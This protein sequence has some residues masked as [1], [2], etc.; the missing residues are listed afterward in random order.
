MLQILTYHVKHKRNFKKELESA[1][2]I[3][4]YCCKHKNEKL[5]SKNFNNLGLS[6]NISNQIIRKYK[7][8]KIKKVSNVNLII[9][10]QIIKSKRK[11]GTT[12]LYPTISYNNG[13]VY[14]K[15]LKTE[16]RWNCG[17]KFTKI[18]Q[19]EIDENK[20]MISV[21]FDLDDNLNKSK[22]V[23]GIDHNCGL[24][25][26]IINMANLN[27]NQ[28]INL[29]KE[30]PYIRKKYSIKRKSNK[31]KGNKESRIMKDLDH[32]M[33]DT[34][35]KYA[36]ENSLTIVM[37][38]LSGIRNTSKSYKKSKNSK[39]KLKSKKKGSREKN[40]LINSWSFYRLQQFVEYK[41]KKYQIPFIKVDP[42]YT[43]Q[44]CSYCNVIGKRDKKSFIC[45][46]K[47]CSSY[48]ISRNADVNACYNIG[49]RGIETIKLSK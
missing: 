8:S 38:K 42:H 7:N 46:N 34:I 37:E 36:K 45:K 17:K 41:S 13:F 40:R 27:N 21:S 11:D 9:S 24:G 2:Y 5:T 3:A 18:N 33:S 4:N 25:R 15:P 48:N 22:G 1:T 23:L 32:K 19:I 35:V 16:F 31:I 28:V 12:I 6:S 29:C 30:A 20:F 43:S 39:D 10:N 26:H 14:I 47:K 44:Q 49:K